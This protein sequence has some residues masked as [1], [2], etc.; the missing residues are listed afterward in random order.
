M[1]IDSVLSRDLPAMTEAVGRAEARTSVPVTSRVD[2]RVAEVDFKER[3]PVHRGQF[4]VRMDSATLDVQRRQAEG[5][6]RAIR[7]NSPT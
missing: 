7:R 6:S 4:L 2:G 5:W 3:K 1:T